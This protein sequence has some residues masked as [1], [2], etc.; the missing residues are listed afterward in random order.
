[1]WEEMQGPE[2]GHCC[3]G[4]GG[5]LSFFFLFHLS[6]N[7]I[8]WSW[9][10]I[11]SGICVSSQC[12]FFVVLNS[13]DFKEHCQFSRPQ[14]H[15][16]FNLNTG[17]TS[18]SPKRNIFMIWFFYQLHILGVVSFPSPSIPLCCWESKHSGW[19]NIL[20]GWNPAFLSHQG[21]MVGNGLGKKDKLNQDFYLIVLYYK[22][23]RSREGR[24]LIRVFLQR[25]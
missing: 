11:I 19:E 4:L 25:I 3:W 21:C 8:K 20:N 5:F 6:K 22:K 16:V 24:W 10:G 13:Y 17:F 2:K 14:I 15:G 1:M 12:T 23:W 7:K 9:L 18:P